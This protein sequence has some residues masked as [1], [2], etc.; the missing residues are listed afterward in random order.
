MKDLSHKKEIILIINYQINDLDPYEVLELINKILQSTNNISLVK[1]QKNYRELNLL[2]RPLLR[3]M[4]H[5]DYLFYAIKINSST[6]NLY[7]HDISY[8]E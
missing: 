4:P 3:V 6:L 8:D 2:I 7:F 5:T 1:K